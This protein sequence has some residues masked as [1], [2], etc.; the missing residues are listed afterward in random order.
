VID[1]GTGI[2]SGSR[3]GFPT[4]V[5]GGLG[6]RVTL[7]HHPACDADPS[8]GH[9]PMHHMD[10]TPYADHTQANPAFTHPK[11]V[12]KHPSSSDHHS[13]LETDVVVNAG[14]DSIHPHSAAE[15]D[16]P[17]H[18][19]GFAAGHDAD[20]HETHHAT[21][22]HELSHE[23]DR[24]APQPKPLPHTDVHGNEGATHT[25]FAERLQKQQEHHESETDPTETHDD[26]AT[27]AHDPHSRTEGT[28][29]HSLAEDLRTLVESMPSHLVSEVKS[30]EE[31]G[32]HRCMPQTLLE[33][34]EAMVTIHRFLTPGLYSV[35]IEE[36]T[37][38][39][40]A[41]RASTSTPQ[42]A[43]PSY[44]MQ[45]SVSPVWEL[46]KVT[47]NTVCSL[48]S[49]PGATGG[50]ISH[51]VPKSSDAT[52]GMDSWPPE[53]PKRIPSPDQPGKPYLF[54]SI[55]ANR[56]LHFQQRLGSLR[57][58]S[59]VFIAEEFFH[60]YAE[61]RF[62]FF[63]S[64]LTLD[65]LPR[66]RISGHFTS[67]SRSSHQER[68][69]ALAFIPA[70]GRNTCSLSPREQGTW[71]KPQRNSEGNRTVRTRFSI[72]R[73]RMR[74]TLDSSAWS[75]ALKL[76]SCRFPRMLLPEQ[77]LLLEQL[78]AATQAWLVLTVLAKP[79]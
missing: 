79:A 62:D 43:C 56:S 37:A 63:T 1:Q 72:R 35:V 30:A 39:A 2:I 23:G 41:G 67:L 36:T 76:R 7:K 40:A 4:G 29:T 71:K 48:R 25:S 26:P 14:P 13:F 22:D 28:V 27:D 65:L 64:S 68:T 77:S 78:Q 74:I 52:A 51:T 21:P 32:F 38:P 61:V 60:F 33:S 53:L 47:S 18:A 19:A 34:T 57:T 58:E 70:T 9:P 11:F 16:D 45:L 44:T 10:G 5:G 66:G 42:A 75:L 69:R 55:L 50:V 15:G 46:E 3:S 6:L 12:P 59:Y 54:D 17:S 73:F 8:A 24:A 31:R 20:P 49:L